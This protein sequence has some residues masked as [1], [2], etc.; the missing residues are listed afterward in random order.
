MDTQPH[1]IPATLEEIATRKNVLHQEMQEQKGI[2]TDFA[3]GIF[4]P[5]APVATKSGAIMRAF[6]TGMAVFDGAMMGIRIV[7]R[8]RKLFGKK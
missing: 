3:K 5:A 6:N 4:M 2:I 1:A 8:I 7:R